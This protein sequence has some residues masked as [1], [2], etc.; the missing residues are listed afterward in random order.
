VI[1]SRRSAVEVTCS[2][3]DGKLLLAGMLTESLSWTLPDGLPYTINNRSPSRLS[4]RRLLTEVSEDSVV[5]MMDG[6]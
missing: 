4:P 5:G 3:I 2:S 6:L 1:I